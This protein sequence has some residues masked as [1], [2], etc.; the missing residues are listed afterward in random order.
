MDEQEYKQRVFDANKLIETTN[1]EGWKDVFIPR[2]Q[3]YI[4]IAEAQC[5]NIALSNDKRLAAIGAHKALM[6]V[7]VLADMVKQEK[8]AIMFYRSNEVGETE[9]V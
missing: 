9:V 2:L 5:H 3:R 7:L 8:E 6:D 1:T 4:A